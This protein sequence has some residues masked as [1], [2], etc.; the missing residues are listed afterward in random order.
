MPPRLT[1][2]GAHAGAF[3]KN[4]VV[5][6]SNI[7]AGGNNIWIEPKSSHVTDA[8]IAACLACTPLD[9]KKISQI[10]NSLPTACLLC[11]AKSFLN[12]TRFFTWCM[13]PGFGALGYNFLGYLTGSYDL[14]EMVVE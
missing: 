7:F 8:N 10:N 13:T 12:Y 4:N 3:M 6:L 2:W 9:S 1:H 14:Y 11:T 5:S